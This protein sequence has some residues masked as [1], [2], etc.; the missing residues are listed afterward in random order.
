MTNAQDSEPRRPQTRRVLVAVIAAVVVIGVVIAL[1]LTLGSG[2]GAAGPAQGTASASYA[3]GTAVAGGSS[4]PDQPGASSAPPTTGKPTPVDTQKPTPVA[5]SSAATTQA[6]LDEPAD[7]G[8]G[9]TVKVSKVEAVEG[10]AQ[11]PGEI[12]GPGL[13]VTVTVV[14]DTSEALPMDLALA[15]LYYGKDERPAGTQSGPGLSPLAQP[16][17]AGDEASGTYVFA[18]PVADRDQI[19]VEFSYTTAAPTVIFNGSV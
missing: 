4:S 2:G 7:L 16:I 1:V 17:P 9:V 6:P 12:A 13:R 3:G 8:N 14:N 5:P 18:V 11:G 15:N 19:K 10:E